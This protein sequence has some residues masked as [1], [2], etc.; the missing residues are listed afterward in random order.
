MSSRFAFPNVH[1]PQMHREDILTLSR[2]TSQQQTRTLGS[3]N[4]N[5]S[6]AS[7]MTRQ[8]PPA[9]R[10]SSHL[11]QRRNVVFADPLA[12]RYLEDDPLA[13]I[14]E[15]RGM[16]VGY[17]LYLVEQWACSRTHPTFIIAT[18]TGDPNHVA[19]VGV[20]G[21]PADEDTWSP[22]IRVYFKAVAQFHARPK[23]TPKG[24][25]M[26]TNLSSFP[27]ALTVIPVP[28]GDITK[29]R[30]DFV[31][32]ENLKRLGCSGRSGMSL[33]APAGATQAKFLQLYKTS[34]RIPL[35]DTV[36][37]LVKLCQFA[38]TVF[39]KLDQEYMDGMLCDITEQ[40]I[41][42]WWTEI[43]SEYFNI[44]PTD[45]ILGPTTV[46]A[47]L[48][49]LM[50]ARNR[51]NWYGAPVSKDTFDF[52]GLKR[53]VAYFQKSQ[54]M[55][56]TK[57]LDRYTLDRLHRVTA[58][59]AAGEGWAVPKAVKSTVVELSGK[60]GEMVMGMVGRD[61]P[62]IGDIETLDYDRFVSLLH[63][64]RAKW[65][66]YGKPKRNGGTEQFGGLG[67]NDVGHLM[68]QRDDQGGYIWSHTKAEPTS[69]EEESRKREDSPQ[70]FYD[71]K[72]LG[73]ATSVL[74]SPND[75]DLQ[76]R[77]TVFKSVTGKM[78]DARTGFGRI[79]D[80]VGL[81]GHAGKPYKDDVDV[82]YFNAN[83]SSTTFGGG[84]NGTPLS[85]VMIGKAFTW[86]DTPAQYQNG[87]PKVKVL[88]SGV[89]IQE[90]EAMIEEVRS[91]VPIVNIPEEDQNAEA[92]AKWAEQVREIRRDVIANDLSVAGSVYDDR[93]LEGPLLEALREPNNFQVLL[94][95]R[96]SFSGSFPI[97]P[98]IHNEAWWP[99]QMSFTDAE[100]AILGW[101]PIGT[102]TDD[103]EVADTWSALH[104][105]ELLSSDYKNLFEKITDL[106][107]STRPWVSQKVFDI[108]TLDEQASSDQEQFQTLYYELT[109]RYQ[110]VKQSS[111]DVLGEERAHV[112]EA[113]K[114]IEVLGAKLE[115]EI[116][117]L[118]S[119]V[120]DV[121]DGVLQ[122]ERQV[123]DLEGRANELEKQL[124]TESWPHWLVR[125]ITGIGTGPNITAPRRQITEQPQ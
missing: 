109:D 1:D 13:V 89:L 6:P 44:E 80:A 10:D 121:E 46:A 110:A 14:I 4:A 53:G 49:M 122:Y 15:R 28:D 96:H 57:Q 100:D 54:K 116:N 98:K 18:Y 72:P 107:D 75:K 16:I 87:S 34:D 22:K 36:L 119:K 42:D 117:A 58:K 45:G 50:G 83:N 39:G 3:A 99:R 35:Y 123:D 101:E 105:Q 73:S 12:F 19:W 91:D 69:V 62:G 114:E 9:A 43:G 71:S 37:E 59:A 95:R 115:Y 48:G 86:K 2:T 25:L 85:P 102:L 124:S 17:E 21:L 51:L 20:L 60:G 94:H 74:E 90:P 112:M 41:N 24:M 125:T 52:H 5:G 31:V 79:K 104:K 33:T 81:R 29:H 27:S 103:G 8:L 32:N 40:G 11:T 70:T 64:E 38:L 23:D 82:G 30:G 56:R 92:E 55:E 108:E 77:K 63:G 120:Q 113:V 118:V 97:T 47:L 76:L 67:D 65:L 66:W 106:Q 93:D 61:K 26:V 68:F 78:S 7:P 88:S 111:Q 84:S